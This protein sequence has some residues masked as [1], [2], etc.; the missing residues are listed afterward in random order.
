MNT[1]KIYLFIFSFWSMNKK[2]QK[3]SIYILFQIPMM[4]SGSEMSYF[5]WIAQMGNDSL[6]KNFH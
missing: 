3:K 2:T 1:Y 6:N 4:I 5:N